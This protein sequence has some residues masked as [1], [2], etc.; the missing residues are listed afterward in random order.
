[1]GD[2]D[3]EN[4]HEGENERTHEGENEDA[5]EGENAPPPPIRTALRLGAEAIGVESIQVM[6]RLGALV[7]D[8]EV[9]DA[10]VRDVVNPAVHLWA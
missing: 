10:T 6:Q 3:D 7:V 4:A 5:H 9:F 8:P 1:M 2:H